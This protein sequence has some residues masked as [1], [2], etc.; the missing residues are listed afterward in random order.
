MV[1]LVVQHHQYTL[2]HRTVHCKMVKIVNSV[3]PLITGKNK[4]DV[5]FPSVVNKSK[6]YFFLQKENNG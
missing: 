6:V 1:V 2:C 3:M 5:I 4:Q